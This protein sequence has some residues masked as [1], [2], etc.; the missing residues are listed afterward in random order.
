MNMYLHRACAQVGQQNWDAVIA[1]L[2]IVLSYQPKEIS[3]LCLRARAHCCK[4]NWDLAMYDY[5]LALK[6]NPGHPVALAGIAEIN[7]PY[8]DLPMLDSSIID[9]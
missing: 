1:D 4:R 8:E 3:V 5:K 2:T 7:Q 9:S 6:I